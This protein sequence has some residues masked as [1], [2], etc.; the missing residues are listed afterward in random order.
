M[1]RIVV[2]IGTLKSS[3]ALFASP[4]LVAYKNSR[5]FFDAF[6]WFILVGKAVKQTFA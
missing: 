6:D 2:G 4:M 5:L 3:S 1:G